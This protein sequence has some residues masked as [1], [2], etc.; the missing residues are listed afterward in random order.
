[1]RVDLK[2]GPKKELSQFV[3]DPE[4]PMGHYVY[5]HYDANGKLFYVGKGTARRAWSR[6]RHP[7][8]LRYVN[9]HL[10]GKY[11]VRIIADSMKAAEAE[12]YEAILIAM[13]GDGLVN[14]A[15][16]GRSTD[17]K[18]LDQYHLLRDANRRLIQETKRLE[19]T[20]LETSCRNYMTAINNANEYAFIE[21]ETG[22]V[23]QLIKEEN[24]ETGR[25]G[26]LMALDRLS[27]CLVK[28]GRVAEAAE[29]STA[30]FARYKRDLESRSS[31]KIRARINK[32]LAQQ[33][34]TRM[35]H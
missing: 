23:G 3:S 8:W 16:V 12:E 7:F 9:K 28:L 30:Y 19:K 27:L 32:A 5:G 10:N 33:S 15:N 34:Q 22:I 18:L 20:D 11:V 2:D 14:W 29:V 25:C 4:H 1:M 31:E 24:D 35:S 6:E 26:E 13:N 17:F 21:F